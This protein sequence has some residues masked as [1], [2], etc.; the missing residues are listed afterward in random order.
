M[1][2]DANDYIKAVLDLYLSLP[3]TPNRFSSLDRAFAHDLFQQ[4]TPLSVVETALLLA[5]VRR[6]YRNP[7]F[8]PLPPIRSLRYFLPVI[9]EVLDSAISPSYLQYLRQ[10]IRHYR[11][12]ISTSSNTPPQ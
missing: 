3:A 10:K 11:P 12:P 7:D 2:T 4:R 5:S 8:P 6:L 1:N 9:E